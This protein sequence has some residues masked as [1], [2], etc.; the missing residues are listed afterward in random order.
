MPCSYRP[1]TT[2]HL[3]RAEQSPAEL[4]RLCRGLGLGQPLLGHVLTLHVRIKVQL[5]EGLEEEDR[6]MHKETKQRHR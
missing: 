5:V 4:P 1:T 2:T 3:F 6:P